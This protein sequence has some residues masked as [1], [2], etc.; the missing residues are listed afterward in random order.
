MYYCILYVNYVSH[1]FSASLALYHCYSLF[2]PLVDR[3]YLSHN[4]CTAD[5]TY[6]KNDIM[7]A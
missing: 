3:I 5:D 6:G 1:M 2:K 7:I 4:E